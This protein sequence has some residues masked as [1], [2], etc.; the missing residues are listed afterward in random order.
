MKTMNRGEPA[1]RSIVVPGSNPTVDFRA[2]FHASPSHFLVLDGDLNIVA[3][4]DSYLDATMTVRK[5]ILGRGI[6]DVFPDNPDDRTAD[7]VSNLRASLTRVLKFGRPDAMPVQKYDIPRPATAGGGFEER[8]WSP[9]NTPV[10]GADGQVAWIIHRVENVTALMLQHADEAA[11]NQLARDQLAV[12]DRLRAANQELAQQVAE[13][14]HAEDRLR[15]MVNELNHRVKNTLATVQAIAS[16]TLRSVSPEIRRT[17]EGRFKALAS[18]HDV[19]MHERWKEAS[20]H[21]VVEGSLAPHGGTGNGRFEVSGPSM[22]VQPRVAVAF[23]MGLHEL[24]TNAVK[25][26][27]LS[28]QSGRVVIRW[29]IIP[30]N[31]ARF[32][33]SWEERG[34][35]PVTVPVRR[36]FGTRLIERSLAQDLAGAAKI[37]FGATGVTC[38][39]DAPLSEVAA[40]EEPSFPRIDNNRRRP[41]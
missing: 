13:R 32:R 7:G 27:A 2:L 9:L 6:F 25:Y 15:L 11:R 38:T 37:T 35:P 5:D 22:R 14:Q 31:D 21:E 4:N 40:I 28:R 17:L 23:S 29:E 12:I 1:H 10:F 3:V 33:M 30:A 34:G 26:G 19:M 39:I 18:V 8:Y 16:Q 20:L 24:A 36:G 41:E